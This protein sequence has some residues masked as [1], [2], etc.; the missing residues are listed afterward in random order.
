MPRRKRIFTNE[1]P[2]HVYAR[3]NNKEWF[4]LP[5]DSMWEILSSHLNSIVSDYSCSIHSFVLMTNH[6]HLLLSTHKDYDLGSVMQWLQASV[7]RAVNKESGRMNHVFG[8]RYKASLIRTAVAYQDIYKYIYRNPVRA[9]I[10][11]KVQDYKY[12]SLNSRDILLA[13]NE[14]GS[15]DSPPQEQ[16]QWLNASDEKL[17]EIRSGLRKSIFKPPSQRKY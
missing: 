2:Y 6:Y 14:F 8:G 12:S 7:T 10:C 13:P 11:E 9:N 3:A 1:Y 5:M 4:C 15:T 17:K 16:L